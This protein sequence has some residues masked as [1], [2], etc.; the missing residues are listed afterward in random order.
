ME[1]IKTGLKIRFRKESLNHDELKYEG[2]EPCLGFIYHKWIDKWEGSALVVDEDFN[3]VGI[4]QY[5][6]TVWTTCRI[7][8]MHHLNRL[9]A[10]LTVPDINQPDLDIP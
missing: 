8:T 4:A 9:F 1:Q 3:W 2:Y 10:S 7:K 5:D 6:K